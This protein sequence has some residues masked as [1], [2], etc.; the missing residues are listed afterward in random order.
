MKIIEEYAQRKV[1]ERTREVIKNM[2][3]H[4][5]E[6][7]DIVRIADVTPEFVEKTLSE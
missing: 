6:K 3:K 5:I 2:Y 1:E 7:E 4:G